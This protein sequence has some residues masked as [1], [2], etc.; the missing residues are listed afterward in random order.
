[1]RRRDIIERTLVFIKPDGVKRGLVGE[2]IYR[3]ER[4]GLKIVGLKMVWLDEEWARRHYPD[5]MAERIGRKAKAAF[6][7][8]GKPFPWTP[9]EYGEAILFALRRYVTSAPIVAMVLEGPHA[10]KIVRKLVGATNPAD[11]PPGTIR[12]DYS[13]DS[14]DYA[15]EQIR[16]TLNIIHASDSP[17]AAEREIKEFFKP[18][19]LYEYETMY[20]YL[21]SGL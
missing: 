6:E 2:I 9:K 13:V 14:I 20:D 8:E 5:E 3:F 1:M 12:G 17:E 7:R 11:S 15:N 16:S 19:E 21:T 10:I 4:A 18:E